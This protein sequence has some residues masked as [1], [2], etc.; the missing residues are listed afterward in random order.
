MTVFTPSPP[1]LGVPVLADRTLRHALPAGSRVLTASGE[2]QV[3]A[4][5]P[6]TRIIT[7]DHGMTTVRDV[8]RMNVAPGTPMIR[9]PANAMGRGKPER[10]VTLPC[11]QP[12]VLRDWRAKTIFRAREAR[13]AAQRLIDGSVIRSVTSNGG[14]VWCIVLDRPSALYV[15]G[16]ELV[17][18]ALSAVRT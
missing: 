17:S 18:G 8:I 7:R 5:D 6:G 3:E 10:D 16:L 1:P 14:S 9:I 13:V 12:V 2:M 11:D 15:D 4:I